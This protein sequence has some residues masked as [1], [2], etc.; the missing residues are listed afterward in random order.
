MRNSKYQAN[1]INRQ[2][3]KVKIMSKVDDVVLPGDEIPEIQE[4]AKDNRKI[5][6]GDGIRFVYILF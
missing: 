5:I 4:L 6:L 3:L 2:Q 1:I